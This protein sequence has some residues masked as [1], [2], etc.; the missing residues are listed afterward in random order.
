MF[1]IRSIAAAAALLILASVI[2][3][4]CGE[5]PG[6]ESPVSV[7]S[8]PETGAAAE[9]ETTE[10]GSNTGLITR[11]M[12]GMDF[13]GREFRI[14]GNE[15]TD[16]LT[17]SVSNEIYYEEE[18][19]EPLQDA[20]YTRNHRAE[21]LLNIR[22]KAT[23]VDS[24][25]ST[26][27]NSVMAGDDEYDVAITSLMNLGASARKGHFRNFYAIKTMDLSQPWWDQNLI[28]SFTLFGNKLYFINGD[29][30]YRD[31]Y[32]ECV[33]FFNKKLVADFGFDNPYDLVD[34]GTWT[35][36]A[37]MAM[38]DA[39]TRDLDGDGKLK[40]KDD[41]IGYGDNGDLIKHLIYA[42]GEK[43]TENDEDGI[44]R[45]A[46]MTESHINKVQKLY[47][48]VA[49][50]PNVYIGDNN[51]MATALIEGRFLFYNECLGAYA[52]FR[53]MEDDFGILP[54]PKYDE[55]QE[56]YC[57]Y[58]SNGW[59]TT[60]VIPITNTDGDTTGIIME[61][62]SALATDTIRHTLYDVLFNVKYARDEQ[63]AR[64]VD[65]CVNSK[66]YDWSTDF[67]WLDS[68]VSCYNGMTKAKTFDFVSRVEKNR[69]KA[70]KQIEKLIADFEAAE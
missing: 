16:S 55:A 66:V 10:D 59:N 34:S 39:F 56:R 33:N 28:N 14:L 8:A 49:T 24:P 22:I 41:A 57:A 60:Y 48:K 42:M 46:M 23:F 13:E 11:Q 53:D 69:E 50:N 63:T 2:L 67:G 7:T 37:M 30:N 36:D 64:M 65:Y 17:K 47:D 52:Q 12:S 61:T 62:M 26:I 3:P 43:I 29:I 21:D 45:V 27:Q 35:I 38:A 51:S 15:S 6:S 4:A 31:D 32:S 68:I 44:P 19:G 1:K 58:I 25:A 40:I 70:E 54:Q 5:S 9:A 20:V 18:V